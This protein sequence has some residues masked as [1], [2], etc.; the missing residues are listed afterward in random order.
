MPSLRTHSC[1]WC[2]VAI[3]CPLFRSF[4]FWRASCCVPSPPWASQGRSPGALAPAVMPPSI[5]TGV[6]TG[7]LQSP[8]R[9]VRELRHRRAVPSSEPRCRK[10]GHGAPYAISYLAIPAAMGPKKKKSKSKPW[11]KAYAHLSLTSLLDGKIPKRI[12][13]IN[14]AKARLT[15]ARTVKSADVERR[16]INT[17]LEAVD[18]ILSRT[19][20]A[21]LKGYGCSFGP[22]ICSL[23][24]SYKLPT[25]SSPTHPSALPT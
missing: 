21:L 12:R 8:T 3:S 20:E 16:H 15:R 1:S 10:P 25:K 2:V 6:Y 14:A 4:P 24:I 17:C 5:G 13:S 19:R 23:Y 9:T 22:C 11:H 18:S 7:P